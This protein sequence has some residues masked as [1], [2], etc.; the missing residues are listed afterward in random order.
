MLFHPKDK[1]MWIRNTELQ[2]DL[3]SPNLLDIFLLR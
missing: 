3:D 2:H 1:L